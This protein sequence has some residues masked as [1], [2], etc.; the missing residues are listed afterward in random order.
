MDSTYSPAGELV[1]R[2]SGINEPMR[3]EGIEVGLQD[4]T[5][6]G[7]SGDMYASHAACNELHSGAHMIKLKLC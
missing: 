4:W 5:R 7:V 6:C 3:G 1:R 2:H